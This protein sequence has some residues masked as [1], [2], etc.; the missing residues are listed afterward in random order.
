MQIV[1]SLSDGRKL[2]GK[3]FEIAR[4]TSNHD[5]PIGEKVRI[6]S[7]S[8]YGSS[9]VF[10]ADGYEKFLRIKDIVPVEITLEELEN[11][12]KYII[13]KY[14]NEKE[15]LESKITFMKSNSIEIFDEQNYRVYVTLKAIENSSDKTAKEG[16][17][18]DLMDNK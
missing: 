6:I 18:K 8:M 10:Y 9:V 4:N 11:E 3:K 15:E 1:K 5:I 7:V 17:L 14:N 16:L 12:L 13:E 2:I